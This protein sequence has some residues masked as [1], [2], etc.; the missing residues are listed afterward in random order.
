MNSLYTL[1]QILGQI[2]IIFY[3][4]YVIEYIIRKSMTS[5]RND[6][7]CVEMV[8][9]KNLLKGSYALKVPMCWPLK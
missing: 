8:T 9:N 1:V 6:D 7:E 2:I 3:I 5:I 4:F